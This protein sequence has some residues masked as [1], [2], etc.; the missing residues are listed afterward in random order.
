ML[1]DPKPPALLF[2][3][4]IF[5]SSAN[6]LYPSFFLVFSSSI[7]R[8]EGCLRPRR[9]S[10]LLS[11]AI[12]SDFLAPLQ[13]SCLTL[14]LILA[15]YIGYC[16]VSLSFASSKV[17]DACIDQSTLAMTSTFQ[18]QR[19]RLQ[20][21]A[22]Q[23][24]VPYSNKRVRLDD[25]LHQAR[26]SGSSEYA[27]GLM[28]AL[29]KAASHFADQQFRS[30]A[31]LQ[32]EGDNDED[33]G[34][35]VV[36]DEQSDD[37]DSEQSQAS[38]VPDVS[39]E[40]AL[41]PQDQFQEESEDEQ[42]GQDRKPR[43]KKGDVSDRTCPHCSKVCERPSEMSRHALT[44]TNNRPYA[45]S[46]PGCDRSFTQSGQLNIHMRKHY[47]DKPHM[48]DW[49]GMLRVFAYLHSHSGLKLTVA[50]LQ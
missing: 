23:Q 12:A 31:S 25:S 39:Q 10:Y 19:K 38:Y 6:S 2:A 5:H 17:K 36:I 8:R 50:F 47:G 35:Y 48:C 4:R 7:R 33:E 9:L 46:F 32:A 30:D 15:L 44:H 40:S 41:Q 14:S 34:E 29:A 24:T 42:V 18:H 26:R 16:L 21:S 45:C 37:T 11:A 20:D 49:P 22:S 27:A 28:G 1:L 13:V 3:P 43:E